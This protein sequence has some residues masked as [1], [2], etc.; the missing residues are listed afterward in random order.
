MVA[1]REVVPG[2]INAG[3][4]ITLPGDQADVQVRAIRLGRGGFQLTVGEPGREE[5]DG[6]RTVTLTTHDLV[7]RH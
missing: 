6:E 4:V 7:V 1:D 2:D 5:Q 3:D